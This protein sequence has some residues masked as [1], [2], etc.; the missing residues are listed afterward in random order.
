MYVVCCTEVPA[1]IDIRKGEEDLGHVLEIAGEVEGPG[2]IQE[3][4]AGPDLARGK[5][6]GPDLAQEKDVGPDLARGKGGGLL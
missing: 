5:G 1:E 2:Q 3:R 6:V 4:G